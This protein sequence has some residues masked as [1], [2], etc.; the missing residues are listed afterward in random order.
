MKLQNKLEWRIDE[1]EVEEKRSAPM[2]KD[3]KGF[4]K[5]KSEKNKGKKNEGSI[6]YKRV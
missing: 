1:I 2:F 4:W 5:E 3:P 6:K